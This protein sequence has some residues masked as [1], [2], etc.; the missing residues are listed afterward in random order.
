VYLA[1]GT[2]IS[3]PIVKLPKSKKQMKLTQIPSPKGTRTYLHLGQGSKPILIPMVSTNKGKAVA[4]VMLGQTAL[5]VKKL[6]ILRNFE[7]ERLAKA[8]IEKKK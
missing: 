1:N 6:Q 5:P 2:Q 8:T 3:M 4:L 7:S